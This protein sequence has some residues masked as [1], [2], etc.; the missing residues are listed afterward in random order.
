MEDID[1]VL[2]QNPGKKKRDSHAP[3]AWKSESSKRHY[4][5][6][7]EDYK[8]VT[9]INP[10]GMAFISNSYQ[11]EKRWKPSGSPVDEAIEL[12][13][14]LWSQAQRTWRAKLLNGDKDGPVGIT[15]N[16]GIELKEEAELG[17]FKNRGTKAWKH[18]PASFKYPSI[19]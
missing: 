1:A 12:N 7:E 2:A 9:E 6:A 11:P 3:C 16:F 15:K 5:A 10:T 13:W 18:F 4:R 14:T 19:I 17:E 8:L